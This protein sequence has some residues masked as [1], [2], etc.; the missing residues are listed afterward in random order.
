MGITRVG[1]VGCGLM[2][3]G[4]AE[5]CARSGYAVVVR[6][7]SEELLAKGLARVEQSMQRGVQRGKLASDEARAARARITGTTRLDDLAEVD[8]II[9][10]VVEN[11]PLKQE[12]FRELDRRCP[13]STIFASNTSSLSITEMASVTSRRDRFLGMHFFNPVPVMKL[14]ALVRGLQTSDS[15]MAGGRRFAESLGKTVVICKARPG[16]IVT[17][18]LVPY[19]LDAGPALQTGIATKEDIDTAVPLGR[20]HP[21]CP[22]T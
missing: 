1:V 12:V 15:A 11:M 7:V 4:I 10:A 17:L 2:G 18:L 3:S 9:E 19:L 21:R 20:A 13:P 22:L 8:L 6:E 14:V 16:F 5:A